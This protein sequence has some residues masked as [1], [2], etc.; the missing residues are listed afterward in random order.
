M[1]KLK[2]ISPHSLAG[3]GATSAVLAAFSGGAD[4]S[5]MLYMLKEHCD[6]V[7]ATL[8]AAHV[9]H[10]IRGAEA[11]R[12]EEFCKD[13]AKRLGIEIFVLRADVP[14]IAEERKLSIETAARDVRYE[15]FAD[16]MKKRSIPILAVAHNADDNFE[17][18][19][20]NISRGSGLS[21]VAGIPPTRHFD[22]GII[23]RPIL[24][25]SKSEINQYCAEHG[26]DFVTDSTN[27]DTEYTR[28]KIRS[29]VIPELKSICEGAEKAAARLSETLRQDALCLDAMAEELLR[30]KRDGNSISLEALGSAPAAIARRAV[31]ALYR[32]VSGGA[33][34]EYTHITAIL[35][36]SKKAVPHSSLDL[37]AGVSA[38]VEDGLL[39]FTAAPLPQKNTVYPEFSTELC[40]GINTLPQINAEII[41]GNIQTDKNVYKKSINFVID[42]AKIVGVLRA[43]SRLPGDKIRVLG[44]SKSLKKLV[45]EKKIELDIRARLPVICDDSGIVALP[46]VA[47]SDGYFTKN[48]KNCSS[49][50]SIR[51]D[52]L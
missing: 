40:E 31:M 7:G 17:T 25:L 50:L 27:A 16:I 43:R 12:D 32:E 6:A 48:G 22:G 20:F 46:F 2:L 1:K 3:L 4:S 5:A 39:C 15:F 19:L 52:L 11:D 8:Y 29:R 18:I 35:E 49:P 47:V 21:G 10:G 14:A 38:V 9:N 34:L 44:V 41:I 36:L 37:P 28:N 13:V 33:D 51:F 30:E 26:I 45:N 42:S 24:S 23:V